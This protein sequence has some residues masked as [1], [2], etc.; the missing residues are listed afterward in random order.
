MKKQSLEQRRADRFQT[1]HPGEVEAKA[2][3]TVE[4]LDDGWM[5]MK[6]ALLDLFPPTGKQAGVH[7]VEGDDLPVLVALVEKGTPNF[8]GIQL[9][10]GPKQVLGLPAA[11]RSMAA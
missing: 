1:G 5:Q 4:G 10:C 6:D 8:G 11:E 2:V 3:A 7:D 9:H